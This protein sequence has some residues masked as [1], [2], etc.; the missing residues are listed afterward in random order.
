MAEAEVATAAKSGTAELVLCVWGS[1]TPA[2]NCEIAQYFSWRHLVHRSQSGIWQ[3]VW[4]EVVSAAHLE[5]LTLD[6]HMYGVLEVKTNGT[7]RQASMQSEALGVGVMLTSW[8]RR[9]RQVW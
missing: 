7:G 2:F 1:A 8:A 9:S 6:K 3:S 4:Y 5:L